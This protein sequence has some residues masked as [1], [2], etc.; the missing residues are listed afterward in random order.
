MPGWVF[1]GSPV[2]PRTQAYYSMSHEAVPGWVLGGKRGLQGVTAWVWISALV[3]SLCDLGRVTG[4]L[5]SSTF[6]I[7]TVAVLTTP[8]SCEH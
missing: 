5:H 7:G 1:E 2:A 3:H 4:P 6:V 8:T